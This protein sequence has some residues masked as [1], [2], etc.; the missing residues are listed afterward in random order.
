MD[1]ASEMPVKALPLRVQKSENIFILD[2]CCSPGGKLLSIYDKLRDGDTLHGVDISAERLNVCSS[3]MRKHLSSQPLSLGGKK[4][5]LFCADGTTFLKNAVSPDATFDARMAS[6]TKK[7]KSARR[8]R[9]KVLRGI[10]DDVANDLS[11]VRRRG[12]YDFVLVDAQCTHDGSHKHE[13]LEKSKKR[14]RVCGADVTLLQAALLRRGYELLR[15]GGR[16]VYSTCS[17]EERQNESVVRGLLQECA[18]SNLLHTK[19][20]A[21][22]Q[23]CKVPLANERN[24][25]C[26]ALCGSFRPHQTILATKK[27]AWQGHPGV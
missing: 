21:H 10:I 27:A 3:L 22:H 17:L 12:G 11:T 9:A 8:R 2:L 20:D 25:R 6:I 13:A 5:T 7:N 23:Y 18:D 15:P 26:G 4:M 1:A 14:R 19:V 24:S 16:M